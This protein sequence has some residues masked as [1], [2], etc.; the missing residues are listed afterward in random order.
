MAQE[1]EYICVVLVAGHSEVGKEIKRFNKIKQTTI[2]TS[3]GVCN[4]GSE[5]QYIR[6]LEP[7]SRKSNLVI[8]EEKL[9]DEYQELK[10]TMHLDKETERKEEIANR[11]LKDPGIMSKKMTREYREKT[12]H[13]YDSARNK[14]GFVKL[15]LR[16]RGIIDITERIVDAVGSRVI[17]KTDIFE[18]LNGAKMRYVL[19]LDMSCNDTEDDELMKVIREDKIVGGKRKLIKTHKIVK[20][21]RKLKT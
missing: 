18:F 21:T 17:T 8:D 15:V 19:Y 3:P 16:N 14:M 9:L 2:T 6:L 4:Y 13:L 5:E 10:K 11:F 20:K 12:Y 7:Y 1:N